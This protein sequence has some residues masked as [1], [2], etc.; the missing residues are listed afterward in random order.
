MVLPLTETIAVVMEVVV[1]VTDTETAVALVGAVALRK[2]VADRIDNCFCAEARCGPVKVTSPHRLSARLQRHAQEHDAFGIPQALRQS[3]C[4]GQGARPPPSCSCL[5]QCRRRPI[6]KGR[7]ATSRRSSHAAEED[8][9][10]GGAP[11]SS[12]K[13]V[14]VGDEARMRASAASRHALLRAQAVRACGRPILSGADAEG[15]QT[16]VAP[17]AGATHREFTNMATKGV[18]ATDLSR[19]K[20]HN[21]FHIHTPTTPG[22]HTDTRPPAV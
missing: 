9:A 2:A 1:L 10:H 21:L 8:D 7:P 6:S 11:S 16:W 3:S 15:R 12:L 18:C 17:L 22:Q 14:K 19:R 4:R 5:H 20:P 13:R